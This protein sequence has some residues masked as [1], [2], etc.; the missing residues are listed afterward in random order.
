MMRKTREEEHGTMLTR[1]TLGI[2]GGIGVSLLVSLAVLGVLAAAIS[3]GLLGAA[4]GLRIA[5][6]SGF[7][8]CLTGSACA[9]RHCGARSLLVALAVGAGSFL[10]WLTAGVALFQTGGI[11]RQGGGILCAALCGSAAAHILFG[12]RRK[13]KRRKSVK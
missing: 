9:I 8:G 1:L 12:G 11:D 3:N 13:K 2:C 7:L 4:G 6:L 10:L 5:L